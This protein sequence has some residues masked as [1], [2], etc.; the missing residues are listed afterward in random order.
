L[1]NLERAV[2]VYRALV[3]SPVRVDS[4]SVRAWPHIERAIAHNSKLLQEIKQLPVATRDRVMAYASELTPLNEGSIVYQL[5]GPS[6]ATA[7]A[8]RVAENGGQATHVDGGGMVSAL[9]YDT[10][11][12]ESI[13]HFA[14]DLGGTRVV[15]PKLADR[16]DRVDVSLP[17]SMFT[18]GLD[19]DECERALIEAIHRQPGTSLNEAMFMGI[20]GGHGGNAMS[21]YHTRLSSFCIPRDVVTVL[22]EATNFEKLVENMAPDTR[23]KLAQFIEHANRRDIGNFLNLIQ[24]ANNPKNYI[25]T[26]VPE[27]VTSVNALRRLVEAGGAAVGVTGTGNT[28]GDNSDDRGGIAKDQPDMRQGSPADSKSNPQEPQPQPT[29]HVPTQEQGGPTN[30]LRLPDGTEVPMDALRQAF[31]KML[32]SMATQVANGTEGGQPTQRGADQ[33]AATGTE[34]PQPSVQQQQM[35][36]QTAS[37]DAVGQAPAQPGDEQPAAEEPAAPAPDAEAAPEAPAPAPADP[38]APQDVDG[39]L[40]AAEQGDEEALKQAQ[41]MQ[42]Q[43]TPE[44]QARLQTILAQKTAAPQPAQESY[45]GESYE[46]L[47]DELNHTGPAANAA[48]AKAAKERQTARSQRQSAAKGG[49]SAPPKPK[50]PGMFSRAASMASKVLKR[51]SV[52]ENLRDALTLLNSSDTRRVLE[53]INLV[54]S[55]GLSAQPHKLVE[56]VLDTLDYLAG[57]EVVTIKKAAM[58]AL[59]SNLYNESVAEN[60]AVMM[61][62]TKGGAGSSSRSSSSSSSKSSGDSRDYAGMSI[63]QAQARE[64]EYAGQASGVGALKKGAEKFFTSVKNAF[65][66]KQESYQRISGT[67]FVQVFRAA[68]VER[69]GVLPEGVDYGTSEVDAGTVVVILETDDETSLIRVPCGDVIRIGNEFVQE[70]M[71]ESFIGD[72][73]VETADLE[74]IMESA[75]NVIVVVGPPSSGKSAFIKHTLGPALREER[76][77]ISLGFPSSSRL[78]S[79]AQRSAHNAMRTMRESAAREDFARLNRAHASGQFEAR[80][81]SPQF[82]YIGADGRTSMLRAVVTESS[83]ARL[84]RGGFDR[85]YGE[86]KVRGYYAGMRGSWIESQEDATKHAFTDTRKTT[87]ICIGETVVVDATFDTPIPSILDLA[88]SLGVVSTLIEMDVKLSDVIERALVSETKAVVDHNESRKMVDYLVRTERFDRTM[89]YIWINEGAGVLE[90]RFV[91][92]MEADTLGHGDMAMKAP[93]GDAGGPR[94]RKQIVDAPQGVEGDDPEKPKMRKQIAVQ[95]ARRA[96]GT[97]FT[98][99]QRAQ[100]VADFKRNFP[101]HEALTPKA[102]FAQ[103]KKTKQL[104]TGILEPLGIG[105]E[106]FLKF[107]QLSKKDAADITDKLIAMLEKDPKYR[108]ESNDRVMSL[109][110]SEVLDVGQEA[111]KT[112]TAKSMKTAA[113]NLKKAREA[114]FALTTADLIQATSMAKASGMNR[115]AGALEKAQTLGASFLDD[116]QKI[117]G[118]ID[119]ANE[120]LKGENGGVGG[121][122]VDQPMEPVDGNGAPALAPA[123]APGDGA[124]PTPEFAPTATPTAESVNAALAIIME[125]DLPERIIGGEDYRTLNE[126]ILGH[127]PYLDVRER[128]DIIERI[129]TIGSMPVD[130]TMRL[131]FSARDHRLLA[132]VAMFGSL[133]EGLVERTSGGRQTLASV[134]EL[135]EAVNSLRRRGKST[136]ALLAEILENELTGVIGASV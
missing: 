112:A 26:F 79:T 84:R 103:L 131:T 31:S 56:R 108:A 104:S 48:R 49:R 71:S 119:K 52:D 8:K 4:V 2:R 12:Q 50:K 33:M 3:E 135:T 133:T 24:R 130:A 117:G 22:A 13:D 86:P 18:S 37:Q 136:H 81:S 99:A 68:T 1:K 27:N 21:R 74:Q 69:A 45:L 32:Q 73:L 53:G 80:I 28:G 78:T 47:L 111:E 6:Q 54:I 5:P 92:A 95:E 58:S 20:H 100:N 46:A 41:G 35:A 17:E 36:Q 127:C 43:M 76:S 66:K 42:G 62:T 15:G 132:D 87:I 125:T 55:T 63:K 124:A 134:S 82:R 75:S 7:F 113:E 67:E 10:Q 38:D 116:L 9:G 64:Q 77:A 91:L 109:L 121:D 60:M 30:A 23:N 128:I 72:R 129:K 105:F 101:L 16:F 106:Q 114:I 85:F 40:D 122:T 29:E 34:P 93:T 94:A 123:L 19:G 51:E 126:S 25:N 61:M 107:A 83:F 65:G 88:E 57:H 97:P 44:Q 115:A 118:A 110:L 70:S 90:G 11:A 96:F 120:V 102:A 98:S 39:F 14:A 59:K 89:R